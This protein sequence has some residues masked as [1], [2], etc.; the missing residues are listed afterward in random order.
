MLT[1][2]A[3]NEYLGLGLADA[4]ITRLGNLHEFVVR[5]LA[6]VTRV[7]GKDP[8]EAG[9][10]LSADSVLEGTVQT[11]DDRIRVS[12]RMLRVK[13]R[14]SLWADKFDE[15]VENPFALEDSISVRV[16]NSLLS[17]LSGVQ[18]NALAKRYTSNT[19][20]YGDYLRGRYYA[21]KYT[22]DGFRKALGYLQ[23][24]ID[25]DPAYALAYSGL[26]DT[27]YDASNMILPPAEAMPKAKAAAQKAAA[28]DPSLA[29]A[30]VSLGLIAS[31][32]EWD[33]GAAEREFQ[34][35]L[36]LDPNSATAHQWFGLYRAQLGDT[37]RGVAELRAGPGIRPAFERYQRLPGDNSLLGPAVRRSPAA[38]GKRRSSSIPHLHS[39][40]RE[41]VLLILRGT[42]PHAGGVGSM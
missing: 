37:N 31:K 5:P 25:T 32:Y 6:S 28:L 26:A 35:A 23:N 9:A 11:G 10:E 33:W 24:A 36:S 16:A 42:G 38:G 39:G 1:Q 13:D 18:Q 30:H 14:A 12:V 8:F 15:P 2:D 29:E 27:Y 17:H 41:S 19:A 4:L 7:A 40:L 34:A 20:A 3:R 21:I 22:E